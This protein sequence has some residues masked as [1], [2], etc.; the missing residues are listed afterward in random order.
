MSVCALAIGT[1]K[2]RKTERLKDRPTGNLSFGEIFIS[3]F[4]KRDESACADY[5]KNVRSPVQPAELID[6]SDDSNRTRHQAARSVITTAIRLPPFPPRISRC[7]R[8]SDGKTR[9][10]DTGVPGSHRWNTDRDIVWPIRSMELRA[11]RPRCL[12]PTGT[13]SRTASCSCFSP[14]RS[15]PRC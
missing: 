2:T 15:S 7:A 9:Q 13:A 14:A 4:S 10:R 1:Q 11:T 3:F 12:R 8:E 5:Q 6:C